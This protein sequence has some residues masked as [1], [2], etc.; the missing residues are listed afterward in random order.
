VSRLVAG[1]LTTNAAFGVVGYALLSSSL[2]GSRP[3][4][5]ARAWGVALL[6]GAAV[7]GVVLC[8]LAVTGLPL[9]LP[10]VAIVACALSALGLLLRSRGVDAGRHEVV[11][12]PVPDLVLFVRAAVWAIAALLVFAAFRTEASL[13]D[14]WAFWLP[15]GLLATGDGLH[16]QAFNG[17]GQV[18]EFANPD[19][20]LWWSIVGGIDTQVVGRVDLRALDAQIALLF[21]A[22]IAA[23]AD[24]L[25]GWLRPA[26]LWPG[27]LLV[28]A[29]PEISSQVATG[30]ADVP[31][32][33]YVAVSVASASMFLISGGRLYVWLTLACTAAAVN[34]KNEGAPLIV[35]LLV[36]LLLAHP[37]LQRRRVKQLGLALV[38]A[39]ALELPW[40]IWRVAHDVSG[41][42]FSPTL[43][44]PNR[45]VDQ[46][47]RLSPAVHEIAHQ[48]LTNRGWFWMLPL[49]CVAALATAAYERDIFWLVPLVGIVLGLAFFVCVYWSGALELQFWLA[50]S[51][52][53]VVDSVVLSA[54]VGLAIVV[55]QLARR[56]RL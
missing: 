51:A 21:A 35:C 54:A 20:P 37:R 10:T 25:R 2:R 15:K 32:A 48:A 24:I 40:L 53:R 56:R 9:T 17:D 16:A 18:A 26:I 49:F 27:L 38:G 29:A 28:A 23:L 45:L 1:V 22:F 33:V 5:W 36:P 19:Y 4:R 8:T 13:N 47:D 41:N 52:S 30:A 6:T 31:L 44:T 39:L 42:T 12:R 46:V 7:L 55:E 3:G 50:T 43:F 14:A 11:S 34:I